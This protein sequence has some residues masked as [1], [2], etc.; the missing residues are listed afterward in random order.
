MELRETKVFLFTFKT[1]QGDVQFPMRAETREEA[2]ANMQKTLQRMQV[3]LAVDFP[4]VQ[5]IPPVNEPEPVLNVPASIPP[6]VLE[7]RID[8]LLGDMGAGQLKGKAKAD[9]IK[10]W[11]TYDFN[12]ANY[13]SIITELEL[14]RTGQKEIPTKKK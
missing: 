9:T 2:G 5:A 14:I 13:T 8:T 12:E 4:K 1:D 3:E 11:T 6:E 10:Q 7:L